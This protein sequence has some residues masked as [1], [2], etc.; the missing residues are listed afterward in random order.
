MKYILRSALAGCSVGVRRMH[1]PRS[2]LVLPAVLAAVCL[3]AGLCGCSRDDGASASRPPYVEDYPAAKVS[4]PEA[5][6]SQRPDADRL[7]VDLGAGKEARKEAR[8]A[9]IAMG[10]EAIEPLTKRLDDG[11]F[12]TRWEAVN[13]MGYIGDKSAGPALVAAATGDSD[14]PVR[15]RSMWALNMLDDPALV[16]AL[17]DI[18][19]GDDEG[20]SWHAAVALSMLGSHEA[21][22][23]LAGGLEH[24]DDWVRWEAVNGLGRVHDERTVKLLGERV[25]DDPVTR[26]RQE[27]ALSL[28]RMRDAGAVQFLEKALQDREMQVR[29]RA[30]MALGQ[31]GDVRVL[32]ALKAGL[33]REED[34]MASSQFERPGLPNLECRRGGFKNGIRNQE[35]RIK[36]LGHGF[37]T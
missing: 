35:V 10:T 11:D 1:E 18:M 21:V 7:I 20:R 24:K 16:P 6:I 8:E 27:A 2:G 19:Q 3:A 36:F 14:V 17:V 29:W 25:L 34:E 12:T 28:G 4:L 9:L 13:I 15:W 26:V 23:A 22:P 30:A 32:P 37:D 31:I 5:A 33:A